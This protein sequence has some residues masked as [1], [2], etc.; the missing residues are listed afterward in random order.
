M[1]RHEREREK[2]TNQKPLS[3]LLSA[4]GDDEVVSD[5][6][7][8]E[9]EAEHNHSLAQAEPKVTP[10]AFPRQVVE[11]GL[12]VE[13]WYLRDKFLTLWDLPERV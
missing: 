11:S 1:T 8:N 9:A 7:T 2:R 5:C 12:R 3:S 10:R 13:R 4:V 6:V